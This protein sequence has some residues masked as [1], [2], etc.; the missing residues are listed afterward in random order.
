MENLLEMKIEEQDK[1]EDDTLAIPP[2]SVQQRHQ[3]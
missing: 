3:A 2:H 1:A